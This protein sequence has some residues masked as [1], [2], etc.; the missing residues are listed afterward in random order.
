MLEKFRVRTV[1]S[2]YHMSELDQLSTLLGIDSNL[3]Q[4]SLFIELSMPYSNLGLQTFSESPL[5]A[6]NH[7]L[8]PAHIHQHFK[9]C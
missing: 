1:M 3:K 9:S 2:F 7:L 4:K 8:C 5:F 6:K